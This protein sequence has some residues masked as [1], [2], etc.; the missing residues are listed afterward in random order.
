MKSKHLRLDNP[1][2]ENWDKMTPSEQG[3]FCDLCSK[4][5][6]DFTELSPL[7]IAE[8][9]K[10][11]KGRICARIRENQL[12][13]PLAILKEKPKYQIPYANVATGLMLVSALT[14]GPETLANPIRIQ[15]EFVPTAGA[16]AHK[17]DVVLTNQ[18]EKRAEKKHTIFKGVVTT[19]YNDKP[20]AKAKVTFVTI[21]K[22]F[23]TLTAEDGTFSL[24]IPSELID[25]AN[26][27]R[28]T[29]DDVDF[30]KE[31]LGY[32]YY[33]NEDYVLSKEALK[34]TFKVKTKRE[35]MV[36]GGIGAYEDQNPPVILDHGVEVSYEAFI[37]ARQGKKSRCNLANKE[38]YYFEPEAAIALY[39]KRA[40]HGLY[41]LIKA[42]KK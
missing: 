40:K 15:T 22:V 17:E 14:L 4:D 26:V 5:V 10:N 19:L 38:Y 8:T 32:Y 33:K 34:K 12:N 7:E 9:L 29:Y 13:M 42:P 41:L 20:I 1:C 37:K 6:I 27:I 23:T 16:K 24:E 11:T 31:D 3:R 36:L 2:R 25:D 18:L 28:V 30:K 21:K 39:G 35:V